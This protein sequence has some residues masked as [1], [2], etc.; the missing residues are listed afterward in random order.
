MV[1][2]DILIH[3]GCLSDVSVRAL[4][5]DIQSEFPNCKINLRTISPS[6]KVPSGI[7]VLPAFLLDGRLLA[8]GIPRKDWLVAQLRERVE[9]DG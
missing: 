4:A 7:M 9:K 3:G 5:C 2:L 8:T 1:C 6:D